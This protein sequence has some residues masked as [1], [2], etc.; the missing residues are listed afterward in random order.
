MS[1]WR[2]T[3]DE[4]LRQSLQ[5]AAHPTLLERIEKLEKKVEELEWLLEER[6]QI[7]AAKKRNQTEALK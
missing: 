7:L 6:K 3:F 4:D 2:E 5:K 1:N